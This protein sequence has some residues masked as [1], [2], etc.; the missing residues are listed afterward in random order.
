M[1]N[2]YSLSN[3]S[4]DSLSFGE[5]KLVFNIN[6]PGR[7]ATPRQTPE[8]IQRQHYISKLAEIFV[9]RLKNNQV[10]NFD[11]S[12]YNNAKSNP[13]KQKQ[14]I[15]S[16]LTQDVSGGGYKRRTKRSMGGMGPN[17]ISYYHKQSGKVL[18][19]QAFRK[20]VGEVH[21]FLQN[22]QN[23]KKILAR[24]RKESTTQSEST[25]E[26]TNFKIAPFRGPNRRELAKRQKIARNF[27]NSVSWAI[28]YGFQKTNPTMQNTA[29]QSK[30]NS[31][32]NP[33]G[34][35][36]ILSAGNNLGVYFNGPVAWDS[37]KNSGQRQSLFRKAVRQ[38]KIP[39]E[40]ASRYMNMIRRIA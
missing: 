11:I 21:T 34:A 33:K 3:L 32:I 27:F 39:N 2:L 37:V 29:I 28:I 35:L 9:D 10:L 24:Y 31:F 6:R 19:S 25:S 15:A 4:I 40:I 20:I 12:Q 14:I 22:P 26:S 8:Q 17:I 1:K 7:N 13:R 16:W 30:L 38:F 36:A 5:T 18:T 23:L